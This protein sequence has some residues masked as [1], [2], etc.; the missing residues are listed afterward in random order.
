MSKLNYEDFLMLESDKREYLLKCCL[1]I[2][3]VVNNNPISFENIYLILEYF[4]PLIK[5]I[6][7][8]EDCIRLRLDSMFSKDY[9]AKDIEPIIIKDSQK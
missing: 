2:I 3:D 5:K 6:G 4:V 8:F 1:P 7:P 9:L